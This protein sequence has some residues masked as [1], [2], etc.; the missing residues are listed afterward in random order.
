MKFKLIISSNRL[1]N[2]I[3][4]RNSFCQISMYAGTFV[5]NERQN[6]LKLNYL[7]WLIREDG[8]K[9]QYINTSDLINTLFWDIMAYILQ[10][11][12]AN[13]NGCVLIRISLQSIHKCPIDI[14]TVSLYWTGL[15]ALTGDKAGTVKAGLNFLP[16]LV[17]GFHSFNGGH[18][19]LTS[20][21][22]IISIIIIT[23][24]WHSTFNGMYCQQ[25]THFSVLL[26]MGWQKSC[27]LS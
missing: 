23:I 6:C 3:A 12:F 21:K 17:L 9:H 11:T 13:E 4:W 18:G 25:L 27:I 5:D 8:V 20:C 2:H 15:N 14:R 10:T 16:T 1:S 22:L 7:S 26:P 19:H 24:I